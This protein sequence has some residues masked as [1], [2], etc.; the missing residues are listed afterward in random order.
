MRY[1]PGLMMPRRTPRVPSIGLDSRHCCAAASSTRPSSSSSPRSVLHQQLLDVGEELVQR[2]VEQ[3]DGDG[4]PVHRFEDALEVGA[5][6]LGQLL[7]RGPFS[8][9]SVG[10][11]DEPLHDG[12]PV[13]R[14]TCARCGT[15]RCPRRRTAVRPARPRADRR[16]SRTSSTAQLVGPA[17]NR[18]EHRG[19]LVGLKSGTGP[20]T[21]SPVVPLM[22][23][24]SP[25]R[26]VTPFTVK[27]PPAM[28]MSSSC[29]PHTAGL[30]H[31]RATSAAWL[32]SP[33]RDVRMPSAA[34][35]P[36]MSSGDVSGRTRMTFLAG[37]VVR[38]GVVGGEVH[39]AD[40]RARRHV[41]ALR[42][43]VV[44]HRGIELRVEELVELVGRD[45]QHRL[46][47]RR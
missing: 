33:P 35:M 43:R 2:R 7:E 6:E 44:L 45:A 29:A 10:G 37:R 1:R 8:S 26:T 15:T 38:L 22:E 34:I 25:W 20:M 23:I 32:A 19:E 14:G 31:P 12:Q 5:L 39:L 40:R 27:L 18:L 17:Q 11:E 4:Q 16:S 13:A 21:T 42:D 9:A 47:A 28:S 36:W 41:E 24:T 46:R 3:P 30:P